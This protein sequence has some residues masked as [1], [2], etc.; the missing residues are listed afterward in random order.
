MTA[1]SKPV[2]FPSSSTPA[3]RRYDVICRPLVIT[4]PSRPLT[5][6]KTG[7]F[8]CTTVNVRELKPVERY[9]LL[10]DAG[11]GIEPAMFWLG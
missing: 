3:R 1:T 11:S 5:A 9:R 8:G 10:R 7:S 6:V 2:M 4:D